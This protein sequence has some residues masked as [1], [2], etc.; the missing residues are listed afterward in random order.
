[1]VDFQHTS[2]T[3][4]ID[5]SRDRFSRPPGSSSGGAQADPDASEDDSDDDD[6]APT[7]QRGR[8]V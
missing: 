5:L 4:M 3:M 2:K 8:Y 6:G 1:M 7:A